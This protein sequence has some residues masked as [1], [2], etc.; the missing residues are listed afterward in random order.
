MSK[1]IEDQLRGLEREQSRLEVLL[2]ADPD[3]QAYQAALAVGG[4]AEHV[5]A[6]LPEAAAENLRENRLFK[7]HVNIVRARELLAELLPPRP[8][9]A[10]GET[11][12]DVNT[13]AT[14][15]F[16]PPEV[17]GM[18][19]G[20]TAFS[21]VSLEEIGDSWDAS[22]D[23]STEAV[24]AGFRTKIKVKPHDRGPNPGDAPGSLVAK[25]LGAPVAAQVPAFEPDV[26]E[27]LGE[28]TPKHSL[29]VGAPAACGRAARHA[30][31]LL[32]GLV[33]RRTRRLDVLR[34]FAQLR[35]QP[36]AAAPAEDCSVED[37]AQVPPAAATLPLA[38]AALL[39]KP[40]NDDEPG[41][42]D[43][44]KGLTERHRAVLAGHGVTECSQIAR[45]TADDV[46]RFNALLGLDAEISGDQ[47]I[48]QAAMLAA[49]KSTKF[50]RW[51]AGKHFEC[52]VERPVNVAWEPAHVGRLRGALE[53]PEP[54]PVDQEPT[55]MAIAEAVVV[56][57]RPAAAVSEARGGEI[58]DH[59]LLH[60]SGLLQIGL[61][62]RIRNLEETVALIRSS[63][64]LSRESG[65]A[66]PETMREAVPAGGAAVRPEPR[67]A[68]G[69]MPAR[70]ESP[71]V[72]SGVAEA[73]ERLAAV[74]APHEGEPASGERIIFADSGSD[75][76]IVIVRREDAVPLHDE[77]EAVCETEAIPS[78]SWLARRMA[79]SDAE[80]TEEDAMEY[81]AYKGTTL[82]ASVQ[83][84]R[85]AD[86]GKDMRRPSASNPL[87]PALDEAPRKRG[88][89]RFLRALT[90]D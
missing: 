73:T 3:W 80:E 63:E 15:A 89:S 12:T 56:P 87:Q 90:G 5:L 85:P 4:D 1:G 54:T 34:L 46:S 36:E 19:A 70:V 79:N 37:D 25:G 71:S 14:E 86:A 75:V 78:T 59:D 28:A 49:G 57:T 53:Q 47:W 2:A 52:L 11:I 66:V 67:V 58:A 45:W 8:E 55:F 6:A 41:R 35:H 48:E 7:A 17:S 27:T 64:A 24:V 61:N 83:I 29:A 72:P 74:A 82:E 81:V 50:A 18:E 26:L 13:P 10:G 44:I 31:P 88:F 68:E 23:G 20:T 32:A 22:R 77:T 84:V 43:Q 40:A 39:A 51:Q 60:Q 30:A 21:R 65:S 33:S 69:E 42:I 62:R 9:Q 38:A 16:Q 76:E